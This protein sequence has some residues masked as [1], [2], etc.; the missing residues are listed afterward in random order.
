[1]LRACVMEF[2]GHYDQFLP[3]AEFPYNNNYH[4][5]IQMAPFEA[6]DGRHYH[7]LVGWFE[8]TDPRS[9]VELDDCLIF[10]EEPIAILAR[11]MRKLRSRAI[12]IVKVRWRHCSVE[13]ATWE[14][15]QEMREQ[16]PD[17]F[18]P[19]ALTQNKVK[20]EWSEACEKG[21]QELKDKLSSALCVDLTRGQ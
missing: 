5:S 3:L 8:S 7:S 17:L 16:F 14:T 18:E 15:E 4:S 1:M 10:V 21:F 19:S 2:G 20:F 12:L 6:L 11:D 9:R 13:E